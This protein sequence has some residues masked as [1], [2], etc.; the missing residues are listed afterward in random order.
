MLIVLSM[1]VNCEFII[2]WMIVTIAIPGLTMIN[3]FNN[4]Y[5]SGGGLQLIVSLV[6]IID[7][8]LTLGVNS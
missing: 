6:I 7:G 8:L 2:M 5:Y 4:C 3:P 1:I